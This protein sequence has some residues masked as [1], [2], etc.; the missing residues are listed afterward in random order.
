M[1]KNK[2]GLKSYSL[3]SEE[4]EALLQENYGDK[5]IPV[6]QDKLEKQ[7]RSQRQLAAMR[8]RFIARSNKLENV[9]D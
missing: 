2:D 9:K 5:I 7:Q 8:N 3:S 1:E 6:N 4:I